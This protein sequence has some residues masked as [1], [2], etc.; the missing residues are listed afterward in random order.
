MREG[1]GSTTE[2]AASLPTLV[3]EEADGPVAFAL[4][5]YGTEAQLYMDGGQVDG[6]EVKV[7]FVLLPAR[8]VR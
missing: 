2:A 4:M 7:N 3:Y 1:A 5:R 8:Q 6:N